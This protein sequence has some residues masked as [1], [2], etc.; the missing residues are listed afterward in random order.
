VISPGTSSSLA[1][2][3]GH[4]SRQYITSL[5]VILPHSDPFPR[6]P[7]VYLGA[8][9]HLSLDPSKCALVAAHIQDLEAAERCG[10]RT[11]YVRRETEDLSFRDSVRPR[12]AGSSEDAQTGSGAREADLVVDSFAELADILGCPN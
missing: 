5:L 9:Y 3:L 4:T 8:A 1:S 2:S 6:N 11:I 7:K 12:K 10:Y